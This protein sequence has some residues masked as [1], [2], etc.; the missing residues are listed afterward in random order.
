VMGY[1]GLVGHGS[2]AEALAGD[3][4]SAAFETPV[5][6]IEDRGAH[7][8]APIARVDI[9]AMLTAPLERA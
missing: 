6:V 7:L 3:W 8:L 9:A 4:L 1:R 5:K 2:I